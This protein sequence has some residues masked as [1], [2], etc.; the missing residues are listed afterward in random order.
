MQT[1]ALVFSSESFAEQ[2]EKKID[3][4][5]MNEIQHTT[6]S[7]GSVFNVLACTPHGD[8]LTGIV[9]W[10]WKSQAWTA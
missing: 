7:I 9:G 3:L 1:C 2:T 4:V 6:R 8:R 5:M 10:A